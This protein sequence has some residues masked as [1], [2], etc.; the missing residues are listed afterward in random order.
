[1]AEEH[2]LLNQEEA[3]AATALE[4]AV[5]RACAESG[6][7]VPAHGYNEADLAIL[8][9][10]RRLIEDLGLDQ[11]AIEV[12]LPMRQRLVALQAEVRRLERELRTARRALRLGDWSEA[13]WSER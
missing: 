5:V 2:R 6:L 8:R 7:I 13:E 3:A 1:M 12:V 11:S 4:I 9:C 10:V